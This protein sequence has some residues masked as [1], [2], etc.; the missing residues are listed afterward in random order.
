[1]QRID[2]SEVSGHG[3]AGSNHPIK[4]REPTKYQ[5]IFGLLCRPMASPLPPEASARPAG[6]AA[7]R[8]HA[9]ARA[10]A[11]HDG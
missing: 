4:A 7:C 1:M 5:M 2:S 11:P 9:A 6:V 10:D 3:D 8:A